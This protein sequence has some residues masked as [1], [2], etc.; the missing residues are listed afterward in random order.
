MQMFR[1]HFCAALIAACGMGI[2][3]LQSTVKVDAAS[4]PAQGP[5]TTYAQVAPILAQNCASCHNP[6]GGAPFNLLT[7]E[8]AKQWGGQIL[9]V[10]Q[11]RYMPPWLP[12]P[13][14]GSFIGQRRLSDAQLAAIRA[15]VGA[16]MP[17]GRSG[18]AQQTSTTDISE[19]A[20]KLGTPDLILPLLEPVKLA[21]EGAD[22]FLNLLV[23]Y[24]GEQSRQIRA[25]E[26]RASDPQAVRGIWVQVDR[27]GALRRTHPDNWQ[28]GI[29]G[30]ESP[31]EAQREFN[32]DGQL[33]FWTADSPVISSQS[34][35]LLH[36]DPKNDLVLTSHFKTTGR[37]EKVQLTV[38][39]YFTKQAAGAV[40]SALEL[41]TDGA[42]DIPAG[43]ANYKLDEQFVMPESARVRAIYPRAHF[44][45]KQL[46]AVAILPD[47]KK[48]WLISIPKWDVDWQAVY[49]YQKPVLL[50]KGAVIHWQYTYDNSANNPH[51]P[52]D[53]PVR[54][55]GGSSTKDEVDHLWLEVLPAPGQAGNAAWHQHLQNAIIEQNR[56]AGIPREEKA[57]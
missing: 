41:G 44:L 39:L 45:G 34:A 20:W 14:H 52:S 40:P 31:A 7:Y 33:L 15:W 27:S 36:L 47:G 17:S 24:T 10:T 22:L 5:Q 2:S 1:T 30:M 28:Q 46:D 51:N 16:G 4:H 11:N 8:D 57:K 35:N 37:S 53:P 55:H 48:Q 13:G 25:I 9:E 29:P 50:P 56:A 43:E 6:H 42:I 32:T 19:L 49:R 21:G 54:V 38:A 12:A 23:P 3:A 18:L 26:I